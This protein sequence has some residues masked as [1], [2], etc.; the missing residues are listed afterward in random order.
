M[1][2]LVVINDE[3]PE[4]SVVLAYG[5]EAEMVALKEAAMIFDEPFLNFVVGEAQY[6]LAK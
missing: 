3:Q 6:N 5:T 4:V 1:Y 2:K